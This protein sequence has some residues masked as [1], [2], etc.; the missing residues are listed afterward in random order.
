MRAGAC[1]RGAPIV[2]LALAFAIFLDA[3]LAHEG[4]SLRATRDGR[5]I[6]RRW[7]KWLRRHGLR[8][9][10]GAGAAAQVR[11]AMTMPVGLPRLLPH[12]SRPP[13]M[14]PVH[15]SPTEPGLSIP[16][17]LSLLLASPP[18]PSAVAASKVASTT[19]SNFDGVDEASRMAAAR[20]SRAVLEAWS[21]RGA[22]CTGDHA[23]HDCRPLQDVVMP[24][25]GA[26]PSG[27]A[28]V[29]V[30]SHPRERSPVGCH[31]AAQCA[32]RGRMPRVYVYDCVDRA[33]AALLTQ[34]HVAP[35]FDPNGREWLKDALCERA[36]SGPWTARTA[37]QAPR[38]C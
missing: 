5:G 2:T 20:Y 10:A 31:A 23:M 21:A 34:A 9:G 29:G 6:L 32:G 8:A 22:V 3:L 13:S 19:S 27:A 12:S 30:S 33:H 16:A 37:L 24:R 15:L 18:P 17:A 25:D 26:V 1:A 36:P 28:E 14:P 7:E 35:F 4:R 11:Q 38:P